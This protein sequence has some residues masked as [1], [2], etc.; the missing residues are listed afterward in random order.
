MQV[1]TFKVY[2]DLVETSSFSKA[3]AINGITQSAVSQQIRALEIKFGVTLI[4]RGRRHFALTPEGEAFLESA[5]EIVAIYDNLGA[6]LH[7]LQDVIAGDIRIA[8]IYSIGLHE[9][10]PFLKEFR[11]QYPEVEVHVD[12][13]RSGQVYTAVSEG[14][15]DMGL[16]S[17]P[18]KR[19]GMQIEP[20]MQDR[21]VLIC[22]P[23]HPLSKRKSIKLDDISGEKFISFEP[24]LPTRKVIDRY[25]RERGVM[26]T[27]TMEFDNIETVKR[28]VEI[29]NGISIVPLTTVTEEVSAGML[30][31]VEI[32][33]PQ[34]WRPLGILLKRNRS[35]SPALKKLVALL[36]KN[37]NNSALPE[38]AVAGEES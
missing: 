24:D 2:C 31:A 21:L 20:F 36:Q 26:I 13:V 38:P 30:N 12:Y 19:N 6:R 15:V 16:V 29:E 23:T 37:P 22:H 32:K 7:E 8:A 1:E 9:L 34:M 4:D 10:P 28:A 11:K 17:Y 25:L 27:N 5:R 35:R 14:Q 3:A 33:D 18:V